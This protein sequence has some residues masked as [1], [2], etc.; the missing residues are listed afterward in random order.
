[1]ASS[2]FNSS[3][4]D[5]FSEDL[6]CWLGSFEEQDTAA[7][8]MSQSS[9]DASTVNA[10][11]PPIAPNNLTPDDLSIQAL[12]QFAQQQLQVP[13]LPASIKIAAYLKICCLAIQKSF[14]AE[15][16]IP[17]ERLY[18]NLMQWLGECEPEWWQQCIITARG[19][20]SD[21]VRIQD[22]LQPLTDFVQQEI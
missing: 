8:L 1:M 5:L 12:L 21:D 2:G 10:A 17:A 14:L 4:A 15:Q 9:A 11:L 16:P 13:H 22:L 20:A 6:S 7:W 3:P 18:H 19:I